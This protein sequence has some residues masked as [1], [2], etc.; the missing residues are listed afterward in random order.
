M[1]YTRPGHDFHDH[2]TP[3]DIGDSDAFPFRL[4]DMKLLKNLEDMTTRYVSQP[5]HGPSVR[6]IPRADRKFQQLVCAAGWDGGM[7]IRPSY[8]VVEYLGDGKWN[9]RV[10]RVEFD[11]EEQ[12]AFNETAGL[13]GGVSLA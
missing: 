8:A 4:T 11:S 10:E 3:Y 13:Y 9:S 5:I 6:D 12:A 1:T 2:G 7:A